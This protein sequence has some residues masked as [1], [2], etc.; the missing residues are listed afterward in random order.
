METFNYVMNQ[1]QVRSKALDN[2]RGNGTVASEFE[3]WNLQET[4]NK[5]K[6][7]LNFNLQLYNDYLD[8]SNTDYKRTGNDVQSSTDDGGLEVM[9]AGPDRTNATVLWRTRSRRGLS[10]CVRRVW[11]KFGIH[12]G[13][14]CPFYTS[15]LTGSL[16]RGGTEERAECVGHENIKQIHH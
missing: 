3:Y 12:Y 5:H 13:S 11:C 8:S 10:C 16:G 1:W 15:S 4:L 2:R 9:M 14:T 7:N 6:T